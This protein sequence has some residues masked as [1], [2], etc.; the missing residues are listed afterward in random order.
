MFIRLSMPPT[1]I[2]AYP[3]SRSCYVARTD[4]RLRRIRVNI[5]G[6]SAEMKICKDICNRTKGALILSLSVPHD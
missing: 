3:H 2:G 6:L 4:E 1:R 5:I